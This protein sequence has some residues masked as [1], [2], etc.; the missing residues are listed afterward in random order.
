MLRPARRRTEGERD[1]AR[2]A[3]TGTAQPSGA[4]VK[5]LEEL[6]AE[7][8]RAQQEFA[9]ALKDNRDE[10]RDA[11]CVRRLADFTEPVATKRR[12]T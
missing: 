1:E 4:P 5:T 8:K 6:E 7:L 11:V 12:R 9:A 3:S 10:K 2:A